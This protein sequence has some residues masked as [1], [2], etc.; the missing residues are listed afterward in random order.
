VEGSTQAGQFSQPCQ[1]PVL[2]TAMRGRYQLDRADDVEEVAV[3]LIQSHSR[4]SA[5]SVGMGCDSTLIDLD[6]DHDGLHGVSA[7]QHPAPAIPG[8]RQAG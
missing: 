1:S 4:T 5:R 2:P 6:H 8:N 7:M 3:R